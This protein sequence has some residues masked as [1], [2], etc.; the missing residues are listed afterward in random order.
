MA[1]FQ[2]IINKL[3]AFHRRPSPPAVTDPLEIIILENV[4]YLVDDQRRE[5]VFE[6]LREKV[7]LKPADILSASTEALSEVIKSG[8]MNL[9]GRVQ[10]LRLI[11]EIA[12]REF[13]GDLRPV[14]KL[15]L[16]QA[17]KSLKKFPGIGDPG[18]EKILL[19][20]GTHP[21]LAL[22]SNGL[23]VML[24]LGF[25]EEHKNYSTAYRSARE[26]VKDQLKLDCD[27]LIRA[28][29]LLRLHGQQLCRRTEPACRQCPLNGVC[30]SRSL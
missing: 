30:P 6:A 23:R 11:A 20:S 9:E 8:G 25:G 5:A 21:L 26:A 14:L 29:Q 15:P 10:K 28:H 13:G 16:K 1:D 17:V 7:G 22:E 2:K 18:A 12:L 4:A 24:R 19:F 27:W 3:E